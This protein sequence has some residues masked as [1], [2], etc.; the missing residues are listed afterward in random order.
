MAMTDQS[1][2]LLARMKQKY[3]TTASW[4]VWDENDIDFPDSPSGLR[5]DVVL[6]AGNPGGAAEESGRTPWINFHTGRK[7]NDHFLAHALRDTDLWGGY[8]TDFYSQIESKLHKVDRS[9]IVTGKDVSDLADEIKQL[10]AVDPLFVL[11]GGDAMQLTK[12]PHRGTIAH[13]VDVDSES[14]RW[15]HVPHYSGSNGG[16]HRGKAEV[17]RAAFEYAM[18]RPR[19]RFVT[20]DFHEWFDA[21]VR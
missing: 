8:M 17:Y 16:V 21:Q 20:A 2:D 6:I 5:N 10:G 19:Q 1:C 4:A 13:A 7:H 12:E 18:Q 9:A 14:L 15:I 11:I 3:S